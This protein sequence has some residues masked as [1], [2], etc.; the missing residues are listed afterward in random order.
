MGEPDELTGMVRVSPEHA[1]HQYD[2]R[3]GWRRGL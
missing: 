1:R 2:T 3:S